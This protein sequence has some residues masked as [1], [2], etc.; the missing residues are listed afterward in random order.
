MPPDPPVRPL[1]AP[2]LP[3]VSA[4]LEA[5]FRA[6]ED[7]MDWNPA[8]LSAFWR[9]RWRLTDASVV[10][11]G[12]DGIHGVAF[13]DRRRAGLL[14]ILHIGPVAVHPDHQGQGLG[15]ALMKSYHT[16]E[17]I[18]LLT[19]T[20]A[21]R[22]DAHRLYLRLGYRI[23]ERYRPRV[24]ILDPRALAEAAQMNWMTPLL[25][26]MKARLQP[27]NPR[28]RQM[29]AW[30]AALLGAGAPRPGAIHED[31]LPPP[32]EDLPTAAFRCAGA[33]VSAVILPARTLIGGDHL[34]RAKVLQIR[35]V[36]GGGAALWSATDAAL[37]WGI[38][39]GCVSAFALPSAGAVPRLRWTLG[40]PTLRMARPLTAAGEQALKDARA[41]DEQSPST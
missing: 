38:A 5:A 21:A 34:R 6:Y 30:E 37:R 25:W 20:A 31:P 27:P 41:Y 4:L 10:I 1:T 32:E 14:R 11:D 19:L 2:E 12:A 23:I 24:A 22:K 26:L 36:V 13:G 28:V 18:D 15:T 16:A 7:T 29:G 33:T 35:G 40:A 3:S 39:R 17:R 9:W 8:I